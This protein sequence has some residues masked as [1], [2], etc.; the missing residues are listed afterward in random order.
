MASKI[1]IEKEL[2]ISKKVKEE[3]ANAKKKMQERNKDEE[4]IKLS[5]KHL[6]VLRNGNVGA[7]GSFNGKFS[8]IIFK[9]YM[10][11]KKKYDKDLKFVSTQKSQKAREY[12]IMKV[13]DGSSIKNVDDVF[14]NGF[15]VNEYPLLW[16]REDWSY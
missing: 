11:V 16:V 12:D 13:Y 4:P 10:N 5:G 7:C 9:S 8:W 15:D 14:K 2:E 3:I 6:V 1:S